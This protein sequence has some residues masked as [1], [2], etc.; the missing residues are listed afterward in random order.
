MFDGS[1]RIS[2]MLKKDKCGNPGD[3]KKSMVGKRSWLILREYGRRNSR[4]KGGNKSNP[5]ILV[6]K[7]HDLNICIH[8]QFF[9][10]VGNMFSNRENA[11]IKSFR[12]LFWTIPLD[13]ML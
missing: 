13:R 4:K 10:N 8:M 3:L 7:T 12:N 9:I 1:P 11:Y 5:F 2:A 6:S